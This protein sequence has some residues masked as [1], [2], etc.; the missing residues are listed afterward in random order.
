[1]S[2]SL[3]KKI[4]KPDNYVEFIENKDDEDSAPIRNSISYLHGILYLENVNGVNK[5]VFE[6]FKHS[7][8]L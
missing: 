7:T 6:S 2:Y 3:I 4:N 5:W 1:L 8:E